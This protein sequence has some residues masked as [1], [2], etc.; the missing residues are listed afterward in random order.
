MKTYRVWTHAD[1]APLEVEAVSQKDALAKAATL[2]AETPRMIPAYGFEPGF[3]GEKG[4][5]I[6]WHTVPARPATALDE[7]FAR[8]KPNPSRYKFRGF[9]R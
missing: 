3:A 5:A 9:R 7:P 8:V 2:C 1:L 6:E 4:Q